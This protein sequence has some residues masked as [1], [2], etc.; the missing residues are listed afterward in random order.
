METDL[1]N[2]Y[3]IVFEDEHLVAVYK[4]AG[5]FVHR[6]TLDPTAKIF[7]LQEVRNLI[8][9]R[10]YPVHRLDR[11]TSG[12]LLLAKSKEIQSKMNELFKTRKVNKKYIAIVRGYSEDSAII[13]YPLKTDSG[14]MQE[15]ITQF[16]TLQ[17]VEIPES[18]GKFLTSRYSLI[19][20]RPLT[21]RMHQ[22]RKH[23]AH[24]FHPIIGDR[25]HGCNKQNKFFLARFGLSGMMLHASELNFIH[26]V[27]GI[28]ITIKAKYKDE[29]ARIFKELGFEN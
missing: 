12:V 4:P 28:E 7:M 10:V 26:P 22:I 9:C 2:K 14:K 17:R 20:A 13:D 21:G 18:S 11:K 19:E 5:I 6:S 24:I 25:P 3:E 16:V 27:I 15:A 1:G 8:G 29:F 23:L